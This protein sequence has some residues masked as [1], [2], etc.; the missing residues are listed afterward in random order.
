MNRPQTLILAAVAAL[1]PVT[2]AA[3]AESLPQYALAT[4]QTCLSV[5]RR[6]GFAHRGPD[7]WVV[8]AAGADALAGAPAGAPRSTAPRSTAPRSTAPRATAPRAI[9]PVVVPSLP[10]DL[11][12][13]RLLAVRGDTILQRRDGRLFV[14][15]SD[16]F[17]PTPVQP[18]ELR[19]LPSEARAMSGDLR[20]YP[21]A[22]AALAVA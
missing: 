7:G 13:H 4:V 1:G 11:T 6:L 9:P 20:L 15:A 5:V 12:G 16:E 19:R 10:E 8:T 14:L 18:I 17:N 3:V 22:A 2:P 21:T